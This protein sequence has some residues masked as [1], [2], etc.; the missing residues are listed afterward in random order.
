MQNHLYECIYD[1]LRSDIMP[2]DKRPY[3]NRYK[4]TLLRLQAGKMQTHLLHTSEHDC[5]EEEQPSPY[6]IIRNKQRREKRDI[7]QMIEH[8]GALHTTPHE[9]T[10][11]FMRHFTGLSALRRVE[12]ERMQAILGVI[13]PS[14]QWEG[15]AKLQREITIKI[16]TALSSGGKV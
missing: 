4:A 7:R 12:E 13:Q 9:I 10:W 3:L 2:N 5:L 1:L 15:D 6:H 16:M 14:P 11:V 8:T